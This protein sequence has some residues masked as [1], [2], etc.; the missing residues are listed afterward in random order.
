MGMMVNLVIGGLGDRGGNWVFLDDLV[1][2]DKMVILGYLDC[3]ED[4]GVVLKF[5]V[6]LVRFNCII[7]YCK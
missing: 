1:S 2:Q 3:L 6:V 5:V 4:F 7:C